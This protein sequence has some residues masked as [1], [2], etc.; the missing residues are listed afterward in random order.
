MLPIDRFALDLMERRHKTIAQA[1][2]D[3]EFH[4]VYHT[5][6]NLCTVDLSA[7]YLDIIK[8]RLYVCAGQDRKSAQTV[9]WRALLILLHDMAPV[10]S[11]TAEEAYQTLSADHRP[12]GK[13]VFTM[14][15]PE[16]APALSD[17]VRQEFELLLAV[18]GE[19]TKTVEPMRKAGDIGHS[20]KPR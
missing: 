4:K 12:G 20:W 2:E 8:D 5:L 3:F 10:L 6:H 9:L 18:R 15:L 1:Y 7:F 11:F 16:A 19:V 13:S 17:A 14:R